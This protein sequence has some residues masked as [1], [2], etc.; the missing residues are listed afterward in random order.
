MTSI[1]PN[2][3]SVEQLKRP[4]ISETSRASVLLALTTCA[5]PPEGVIVVISQAARGKKENSA[6]LAGATAIQFKALTGK[7]F[8]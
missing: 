8:L 7:G 2:T 6:V 5:P 1:L 3:A 4:I